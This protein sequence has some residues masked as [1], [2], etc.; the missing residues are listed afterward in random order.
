[1]F[2]WA[3]ECKNQERLSLWDAWHQTTENAKKES[4]KPLLAV[5]K[6]RTDVLIVLKATDFFELIEKVNK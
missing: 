1:L 2:P 5:K 4:L 6:N 3:V